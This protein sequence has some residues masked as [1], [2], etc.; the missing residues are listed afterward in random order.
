MAIP[1]SPRFTD[2]QGQYLAFIHAYAL[3]NGRPPAEADIQR[4]F[5]VTPPSVHSMIKELEGRG[6]ITRVPRQPRSI[7]VSVPEDELP[8]LRQPIKTTVAGY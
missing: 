6:L 2:T 1:S 7:A 5:A 4:F 3:I 8:R